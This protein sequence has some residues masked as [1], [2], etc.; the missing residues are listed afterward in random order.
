MKL[1]THQLKAVQELR[2]GKI[3]CGD[4]GS[5]KTI[6]ALSYFVQKVT[7]NLNVPRDLYVI[8]TARKRDDLDWEKEA[9]TLGLSVDP[10]VS[11]GG[12]RV[13]VDSW[14]S[15]HKYEDVKGAFFIF[16]EQRLVGSGTW[17]KT[18]YKIAA[19]NQ[20]IMLSA[21][22]GDNWMDYI[23]V[24]V[25]NG[26]YKNRS[27]FIEEHVIYKPYR[28]FPVV[29][30]YITTWLLETHRKSILVEMPFDRGSLRHVENIFTPYDK[31]ALRRVTKDRWNQYKERPIRNSAE[32]FALMRRVLNGDPQRL[33][34]VRELLAKHPRMII[35][36]NFD[37]ELELLRGFCGTE[38]LAYS[39]WNGHKHEAVPEGERWVYLVQYSAGSEAWNCITTDTMVFYSLNYSYKVIHQSMGRIDRLNSP[40]M[41]L[42]YYT[43]RT[44]APLDTAIVKAVKTK[45]V[46]SESAFDLDTMNYS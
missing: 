4:V 7:K 39:E 5:G 10:T 23:P 22:P 32:L 31:E 3:L 43:L 1:R 6:T 33:D 37:Y 12:I 14:Q 45:K 35:F 34:A 30:R 36:Y 42:Y 21:T 16:D 18:F 29:D 41:H 40:Y 17:V 13:T 11:A 19:R 46:F 27:Q 9:A 2:N 44:G 24:F 20:W 25:A 28:Q 15:M 8:T 26:I 38:G